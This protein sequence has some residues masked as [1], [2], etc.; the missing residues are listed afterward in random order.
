M[1][2]ST[3]RHVLQLEASWPLTESLAL[4]ANAEISRQSSNLAVFDA[5]QRSVYMGLRW[6]V[7]Q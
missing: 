5:R 2:R 3:T 6:E 7:M 4:V 1:P